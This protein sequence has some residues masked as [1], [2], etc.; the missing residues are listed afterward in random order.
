MTKWEKVS[1]TFCERELLSTL[2]N[3]LNWGWQRNRLA[4]LERML[5]LLD[6]KPI[7]D[8]RADVIRIGSIAM[9]RVPLDALEPVEEND[10]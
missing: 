8:N 2:L 7:P 4:D 1:N 3:G 5:M 10:E 6:V 9:V